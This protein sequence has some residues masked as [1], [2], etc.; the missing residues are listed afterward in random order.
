MPYK[1]EVTVK[2]LLK[3]PSD[4]PHFYFRLKGKAEKAALEREANGIVDLL[5]EKFTDEEK[6]Y[7]KGEVL[8]AAL[9]EGFRLARKGKLK[10]EQ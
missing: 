3:K 1:N 10:I 5:N 8:K 7:T 2:R 6:G 9:R 4:Y